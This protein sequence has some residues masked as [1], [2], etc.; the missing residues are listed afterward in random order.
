[1]PTAAQ[2]TGD[3]QLMEQC[4]D[5]ML[6]RLARVRVAERQVGPA[7]LAECDG[8]LRVVLADSVM[9][10]EAPAICKVAICMSSSRS[11]AAQEA[12]EEYR[13]RVRS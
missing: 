12:T 5:H 9:S 11:R 13:R 8:A 6:S 4:V 3:R 2:A 7:V 1:M 10:G